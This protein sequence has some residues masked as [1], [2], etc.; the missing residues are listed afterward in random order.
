LIEEAQIVG[1]TL[2]R[3]VIDQRLFDYDADTIIVD[4]ASIA[5]LPMLMFSAFLASKRLLVFGDFRQLPPICISPK[6]S[7]KRWLGRD[8]FE[9]SGVRANIEEG[10]ACKAVTLLATQYR[11]APQISE[12]VNHFAYGGRL[13]TPDDAGARTANISGLAPCS[14]KSVVLL[15]TTAMKP[16][17]VYDATPQSSSRVNPLHAALVSSLLSEIDCAQTSVG[18]ITPYRAQVQLLRAICSNRSEIQI[19]T[20][21]R[22][23]GRECD[24]AIID[25]VDAW[26]IKG[27]SY[28]TGRD[29][30]LALR[31][32]N[33]AIS[34]PRGKVIIIADVDFI[35]RCHE[36]NSPAR[37]LIEL[38]RANNCIVDVPL[39]VVSDNVSG[40]ITWYESWQE[41]APEVINQ[42]NDSTK[43]C[44][45][46]L[47]GAFSS[48]YRVSINNC[49]TRGVT[50]DDY[51]DNS[52]SLCPFVFIDNHQ[53][54]VGGLSID[55]PVAHIDSSNFTG[56]A[57][58]LLIAGTDRVKRTDVKADSP[59]PKNE[60]SIGDKEATDEEMES[61]YC[62]ASCLHILSQCEGAGIPKPE[63]GYELADTNGCII[64][65]AELAWPVYRIAVLL[66]DQEEF[67]DQF[68]AN[69]W[70]I[71][72]P[73]SFTVEP[74]HQILTNT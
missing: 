40:D 29:T 4:E 25:L 71:L 39:S 18:V 50:V 30:D 72:S 1:A 57:I 46:N 23:Q 66:S 53:A 20:V 11:M 19:A 52:K 13:V 34:R 33:V 70:Q 49:H 5:I 12:I 8:A 35:L 55:S 67:R 63:V 38:V 2:S 60:T 6:R 56:R 45:I 73:E 59:K 41:A 26:P 17:C 9:V 21:H 37:K 15:N 69:G 14:G 36:E 10:H 16:S 54:F 65:Y 61:D 7:V 24:V 74:F 31:L 68:I 43:R 62:D 48:T 27:A 3:L 51:T 44:V 42:L 64:A 32:L 47:P 58:S 22:F 28:L